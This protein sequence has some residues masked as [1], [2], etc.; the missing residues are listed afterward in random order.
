M[1][2]LCFRLQISDMGPQTHACAHGNH[3]VDVRMSFEAYWNCQP[4]DR[5]SSSTRAAMRRSFVWL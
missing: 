5:T 2:A 4:T 3:A 1:T